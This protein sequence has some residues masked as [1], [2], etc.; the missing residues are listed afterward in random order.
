MHPASQTVGPPLSCGR[1]A[2]PI[3]NAVIAIGA[4]VLY[5]ERPQVT[6]TICM[7]LDNLSYI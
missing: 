6:E 7:G 2:W 1:Y 5:A 4:R 3:A